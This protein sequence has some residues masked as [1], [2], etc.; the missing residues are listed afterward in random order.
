MLEPAN[1]NFPLRLDLPS[2]AEETHSSHS[3]MRVAG[4]HVRAWKHE[5]THQD[6]TDRLILVE[7]LFM[8]VPVFFLLNA[9]LLSDTF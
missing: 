7:H 8:S 1:V 3:I 5:G 9:D 6:Q 4:K 2:T